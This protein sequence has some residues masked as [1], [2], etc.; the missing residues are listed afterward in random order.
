MAEGV[1]TAEPGS[2]RFVRPALRKGAA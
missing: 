2:G 1:V